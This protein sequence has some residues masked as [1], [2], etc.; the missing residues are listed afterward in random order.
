MN[1]EPFGYILIRSIYEPLFSHMF[2]H[3]S[4][5]AMAHKPAL[6]VD[7]SSYHDSVPLDSRILE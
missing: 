2:M 4:P 7:C 6:E 5:K 1:A 3:L